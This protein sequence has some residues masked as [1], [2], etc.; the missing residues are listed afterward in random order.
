MNNTL[1]PASILPGLLE[2]ALKGRLNVQSLFEHANIDAETV[3]SA[4][5]FI[6]L[7]QLDQLL[8]QAFAQVEDPWFGFHV[9]RDNHYGNLDLLGNLMATS[10]TLGDALQCLLSYKNLLVPY[11]DFELRCHDGL[12]LLGA[13]SDDA[14]GFT[15]TRT[16]NDLV[17]TTMVAIGRS[18]VGG[19]LKLR[20]VRFRHPAPEQTEHY[21][22]YFGVPL[23]FSHF[24]ND[25]EMDQSV[26]GTPLATAYPKYHQRLR[27]IADQLL[28]RLSRA[29]GYSAR[30]LA[31]L[32]TRLGQP[33]A[34]IDAIALSLNMTPRTLQRH[35]ATES[36]RFVDLRNRVRHQHACTLL[37][38]TDLPYTIIAE[39]LGFADVAN[40]YHAFRRWEGCAPGEYRK[41][42]FM[43]K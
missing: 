31:L 41:R 21:E 6:R 4:E 17:I 33:D 32:E 43:R 39:Q 37:S 14:L 29:S 20:A 25:I 13:R 7:E 26:L 18:L 22:G 8:T 36:V 38:E 27:T 5:H 28:E 1:L 11:I 10:D 19:N 34:S 23:T 42:E 16:H 40:F 2:I 35:L 3:G 15:S 12:C 30:V 24:C 9:G